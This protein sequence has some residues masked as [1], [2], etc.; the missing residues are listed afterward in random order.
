MDPLIS[1]TFTTSR[2]LKYQYFASPPSHNVSPDAP[3]ILLLHG[4][5]DGALLWQQFLPTLLTL[6]HRLVIP[7]LLGYPP[8]SCPTESSAFN[9]KA[10]SDDLVELLASEKIESCIA[11][12]HDWGSFMASRMYIWYPQ[13]VVGLVMMNVA[14][15]PP[16]LEQPFDV[17]N[18]NNLSEQML[19]YPMFAY[20]E[21]VAQD[22]EAPQIIEGNLEGFW[23]MMHGDKEPREWMWE[24]FCVRGAMRGFLEWGENVPVKA[25]AKEGCDYKRDFMWRVKEGGIG[26]SLNWYISLA[27][28]SNFKVEKELTPDRLVVKAPMLYIG[29]PG[30]A[31]CRPELIDGPKEAGLLP[32]LKVVG[33]SGC[34]HWGIAYEKG[35]ETAGLIK[36][37]VLDRFGKKE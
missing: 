14:Y 21:F 15:M 35:A 24:M 6:P 3:A 17:D 25:Y 12:G 23:S 22:P 9:S 36:E 34:G 33:V 13:R 26:S 10:M 1:K 16:D 11:I 32:D 4:F 7:N 5:P 27:D 18:I 29:C 8:S 2:S 20:W 19:G 31:V 30:D 37:F 28:G